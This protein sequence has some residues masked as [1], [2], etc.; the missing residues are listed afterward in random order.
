MMLQP[1][2]LALLVGATV[3]LAMLLYADWIGLKVIARWDFSSS[4]A[5]Q[6]GLERQT[7]LVSSLTGYALGFEVFSAVLFVYTTED[8]SRLFSGAM[9]ATGVLNANPVG[10]SVLLV[11]LLIVLACPLW[12]AV[13][14]L[15]Q[16]AGDFP[17]VRSK[18]MALLL[19]TPLVAAD[20]GLQVAYFKGL[21]PK[22]ITSCCGSLF[23][24]SQGG[25]AS[26]L[27]GAPVV[28]MMWGFFISI[29]VFLA[30]A[31]LNLVRSS[32]WLRLFLA[33]VAVEL[34]VVALASVVS[35]V[36]L[37]VYQLP[38]HHCPFD[39]LKGEY[40]FVGYPLYVSLFTAVIF[41]ILPGLT[42]SL[43]RRP[44]LEVLIAES[45][46][47]WLVTSIVAVVVFLAMCCWPMLFGSMR[48][49]GV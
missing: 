16:R 37:Y 1:G 33:L 31:A 49:L 28:P 5:A 8:L 32:T 6:L 17:I 12:M 14:S 19:L 42:T 11:K 2:V 39:M 25:V 9:C 30:L 7:H 4:S 41:A 36:S 15:D 43:R 40:G 10:W 23:A 27:A 26:E 38:S 46:H 44:S 35:F 18:Y 48:L 20:L 13:N 45:E 3:V 24:E 29:A 22:I 21:D 47:R 34:L